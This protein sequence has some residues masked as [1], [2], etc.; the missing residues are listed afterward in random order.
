M[1]RGRAPRSRKWE[2]VFRKDHDL[3]APRNGRKMANFELG[4]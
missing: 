1:I 3:V 2:P 4:T